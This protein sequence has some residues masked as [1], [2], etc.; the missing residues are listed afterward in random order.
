MNRA[1]QLE[2]EALGK[3]LDEYNKIK[4][5]DTGDHA[6]IYVDFKV[7]KVYKVERYELEIKDEQE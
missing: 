7:K 2:Y 5:W 3:K 4:A 6:T 1:K